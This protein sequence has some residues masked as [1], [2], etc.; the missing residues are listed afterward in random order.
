MPLEGVCIYPIID[1]PDWNDLTYWHQSGVWD[2][3]VLENGLVEDRV[4]HQP[5]AEALQEA[6]QWTADAQREWV[7]KG[8]LSTMPVCAL[9]G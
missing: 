6:Q 4:L 8:V 5:S 9:E 3:V 2:R 7:E 1:R